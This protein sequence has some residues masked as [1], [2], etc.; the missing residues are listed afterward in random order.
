MNERW[1]PTICSMFFRCG[2][3]VIQLEHC[4]ICHFNDQ[5]VDAL[6]W[7]PGRRKLQYQI[8]QQKVAMFC[9][10]SVGCFWPTWFANSAGLEQEQKRWGAEVL[11]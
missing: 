2:I 4:H 8:R 11:R 3:H 1:F 5:F 10:E 7:V 6:I 9:C